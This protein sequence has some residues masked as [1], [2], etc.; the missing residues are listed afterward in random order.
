[1]RLFACLCCLC[2]CRYVVGGVASASAAGLVAGACWC[3]V[4]L[5]TYY[6]YLYLLPVINLLSFMTYDT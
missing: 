1:M 4:P 5:I 3:H 6:L 2:R